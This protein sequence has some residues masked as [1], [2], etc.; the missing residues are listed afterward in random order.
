LILNLI[1]TSYFSADAFC[2]SRNCLHS[3]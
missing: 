1:V 3:S 2:S